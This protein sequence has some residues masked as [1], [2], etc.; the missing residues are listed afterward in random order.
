[1]RARE[2]S[3]QKGAR[4]FRQK[5]FSGVILSTP[6]KEVETTADEEINFIVGT[7]ATCD[8]FGISRETLS[9]WGKQGAPKEGRGKW[10]L[11]KIVQWKFGTQNDKSAEAR[12]LEAD[13]KYREL[14]VEITEIQ[15]KI[16]N[17][18]YIAVGDFE[19]TLSE[20][21]AKVKAGLIFLGHK[22]AMELNAQYPEVA[23]EVKKLVDEQ[24]EK[25]LEEIAK[26]GTYGKSAKRNRSPND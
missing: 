26:T 10:N 20:S 2:S 13:A 12:K 25:G 24:I 7:Q 6:Y 3:G 22:I 9:K 19:K 21:L 16:M 5:A 14:K 11:K 17:G 15:K 1:M 8:F 18:E 4:Q 23:L